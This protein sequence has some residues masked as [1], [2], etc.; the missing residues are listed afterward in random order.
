MPG[1]PRPPVPMGYVSMCA[2]GAPLS[3]KESTGEQASLTDSDAHRDPHCISAWWVSWRRNGRPCYP[4]WFCTVWKGSVYTCDDSSIGRPQSVMQASVP[5]PWAAHMVPSTSSPCPWLRC[6][7]LVAI[8]VS[9]TSQSVQPSHPPYSA[10][11][12]TDL[13]CVI[14]GL[15][16]VV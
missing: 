8:G 1:Q 15:L 2:L 11:L 13:S 10:L 7:C 4:G 16:Y 12:A 5:A 6:A 9:P 3:H 14:C